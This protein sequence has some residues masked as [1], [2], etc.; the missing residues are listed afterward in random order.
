MT[1]WNEYFKYIQKL[2]KKIINLSQTMAR[3]IIMT[4]QNG[5]WKIIVFR[6]NQFIIPK[7]LRLTIEIITHLQ[8]NKYMKPPKSAMCPQMDLMN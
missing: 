4:I 8:E 5:Q 3:V 2:K 6:K 1:I 7:M